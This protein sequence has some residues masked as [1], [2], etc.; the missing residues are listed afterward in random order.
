MH[1]NRKHK[2]QETTSDGYREKCDL[3]GTHRVF[4]NFSSFIFK[5]DGASPS[6]DYLIL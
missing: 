2:I 3:K 1:G 4:Q 6:I 5:L